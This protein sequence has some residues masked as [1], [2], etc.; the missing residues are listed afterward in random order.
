MKDALTSL[1]K[2]IGHIFNDP[3]ILRQALTHASNASAPDA[4]TES[5]ERM[6]FL[7]DR[8]LGLTIANLLYHHFTNEEEGALSRRFTALVRKEALARVA[9]RINLAPHLIMSQGEDETGGRENPALLADACEAVIAA[10]YLDGGID[11]ARTFIEANWQELLEEDPT[12]PKDAKT[13]L[14]EW[15]QARTLGLP[16]Y[17]L[18]DQSGPPHAP[19][20]TIVVKVVGYPDQFASGPSKRRAEQDAAAAMLQHIT[21]TTMKDR[22]HVRS[23]G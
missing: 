12:P 3:S 7:G 5:N 13:A 8:V 15:T 9:Q 4:R 19:V 21:E 1:E 17:I 22:P 11:T 20:F 2:R 14:Q 10:L 6:E 16:E 18:K 23:D